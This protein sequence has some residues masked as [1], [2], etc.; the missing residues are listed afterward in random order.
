MI[1]SNYSRF[2][3][4]QGSGNIAFSA[5]QDT[6]YTEGAHH[7][8]DQPLNYLFKVHNSPAQG[9]AAAASPPVCL[10]SGSSWQQGQ[11]ALADLWFFSSNPDLGRSN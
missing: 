4:Q 5:N 11:I 3:W 2:S 8:F 1:S 7:I 9:Q 10:L 6:A